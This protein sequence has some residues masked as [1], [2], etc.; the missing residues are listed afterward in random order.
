MFFL[1]H[2]YFSVLVTTGSRV[3]YLS[4]MNGIY[5]SNFCFQQDAEKVCTLIL[6]SGF[7]YC[8][9]TIIFF[10]FSICVLTFLSAAL[11][12]NLVLNNKSNLT[13]DIQIC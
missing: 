4:A 9:C 7:G 10:V 8:F 13:I 1:N 5:F 11:H 3:L 6:L 2:I 12:Y